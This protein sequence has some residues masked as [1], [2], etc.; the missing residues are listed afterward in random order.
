MADEAMESESMTVGSWATNG[1]LNYMRQLRK[2]TN[3]MSW[4]QFA[5]ESARSWKKMSQK[6][7]NSYRDMDNAFEDNAMCVDEDRQR[8]SEMCNHPMGK[9]S[10][11]KS[12]AKPVRSC[13]KPRK[14][15]AKPRK[16]AACGKPKR[17]ASAKPRKPACPKRQSKCGTRPKCSKPGPVT[18]NGY[19]NF[20]R[21]FRKKHC[22]LK[23]QELIMEAAKAWSKLPEEKKDRYRRMACKV[24]NNERHKRRRVCRR[25]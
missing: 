8:S 13:P 10:K 16:K 7:K 19:L 21:S 4:M 20:V 14:S 6:E 3:P 23:P 5:E 12:C 22:G 17:S 15:C 1:F 9:Q 24:T 25:C 2:H 18:N 11:S